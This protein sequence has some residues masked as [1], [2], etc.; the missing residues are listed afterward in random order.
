MSEAQTTLE[1]WRERMRSRADGLDRRGMF[2][3]LAILGPGIIAAVAGDDA[4]GIATY[5]TAGSRYGYSLLWAMVIITV[6]LFTVQEMV[7]RMGAVT[8]KGLSDLIRERFGVRWTAFAMLTLLI[9]NAATTISEFVGIAAALELFGVSK[10]ISVPLMAVVL[11]WLVVRGSYRRVERVFLLMS[12]AFL[13]YIISVFLAKPDWGTVVRSTVFPVIHPE[14]AFLVMLIALIGTTIT[15]YMQIFQQ[16]AI[17]DKGVT[18]Q[19]YTAARADMMTGVFLA[20]VIAYSIIIATAATLYVHGIQIETAAD[21]AIALEPLAG[22]Y[23][24]ILFAIGLFGA[25]TLAA[26]VLP[27]ATSFS[28]CEAFGWQSGL[29]E[30]FANARI[31]YGL[32][33]GLLILGALVTLIP[34]LPLFQLLV[35]VQVINGMLLPIELVFIMR[36][37]NDRDIMGNYVN[38]RAFNLL[39]WGTTII[40]G[41]LSVSLIVIGFILPLFGV[42]LGE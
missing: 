27:L 33:T 40:I 28:V 20:N 32:F 1:R 12:T 42:S 2:R 22:S 37:V 13:A 29:D 3:F 11:W 34:G 38:S 36:L 14:A 18:V 4:G 25:S 17:V 6:G 8:G 15:P 30:D 5:A 23:A 39:A 31:F 24:K 9:A 16:S 10:Y 26:G 19:D 35:L 7:T 41:T 21:A